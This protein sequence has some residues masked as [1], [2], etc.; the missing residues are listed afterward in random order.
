MA[1]LFSKFFSG[2]TAQANTATM[3]SDMQGMPVNATKEIPAQSNSAHIYALEQMLATVTKDVIQGMQVSL[4]KQVQMQ[5]ETYISSL[6]QQGMTNIDAYFEVYRSIRDYQAAVCQQYA[7]NTYAQATNEYNNWCQQA[8][9]YYGSESAVPQRLSQQTYNKYKVM[10]DRL[11]SFNAKR[12]A[13]AAS[14]S[15]RRFMEESTA[16][17]TTKGVMEFVRR[18]LGLTQG[19][20][21]V[22]ATAMAIRNNAAMFYRN[23]LNIPDSSAVV[24]SSTTEL[25]SEEA[26]RAIQMHG[27]VQKL[28]HPCGGENGYV[29]IHPFYAVDRSDP[30]KTVTIRTCYCPRCGKLYI[31]NENNEFSAETAGYT[32]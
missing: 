7:N 25:T 21:N 3:Q 13:C 32:A 11:I 20:A 6:I 19:R 2:G 8:V 5:Y 29:E 23:V 17:R 15:E 26:K 18:Q 22:D 12:W 10:A 27:N 14:Y 24:S 30:T 1:G 4:A 28:Q 9:A 31:L 16:L